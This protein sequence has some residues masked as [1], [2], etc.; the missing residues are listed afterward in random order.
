MIK[1]VA[2][3]AI[4]VS[5]NNILLIKRAKDP[6]KGKWALP[7]GVGSFTR[8][9]NPIIAI[10]DEVEYDLKVK[11]KIERFFNYSYNVMASSE[12]RITL[13]FIGKINSLPSKNPESVSEFRYFSSAEIDKIKYSI[14]FDHYQILKE[15]F[16]K[17]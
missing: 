5:D 12:A 8:N 9:D 3:S 15:F 1:G 10:Q 11:L 16:K 13:H 6:E 4:I 7:G 2:V 17:A 14:A